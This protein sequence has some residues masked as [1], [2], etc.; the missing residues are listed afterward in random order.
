MNGDKDNIKMYFK[1][2]SCRVTNEK[3]MC[4]TPVPFSNLVPETGYP[5]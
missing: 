5:D 2:L 4:S 1:E 3:R